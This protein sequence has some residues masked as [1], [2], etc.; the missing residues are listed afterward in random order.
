M[1]GIG[2]GISALATWV[3]T[4]AGRSPDLLPEQPGGAESPRAARAARA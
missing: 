2:A 4:R 3:A 1:A